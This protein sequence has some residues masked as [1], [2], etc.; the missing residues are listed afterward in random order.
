MRACASEALIWRTSASVT[1]PEAEV[2][3]STVWELSQTTLPTCC[4]PLMYNSVF[5]ASVCV[6]A[7]LAAALERMAV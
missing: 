7:P 3:P 2:P 1:Q 4:W 5:T 6:T